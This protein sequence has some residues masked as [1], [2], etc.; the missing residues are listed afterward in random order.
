MLVEYK[1]MDDSPEPRLSDIITQ[2][3]INAAVAYFLHPVCPKFAHMERAGSEAFPSTGVLA[4]HELA[5][6]RRRRMAEIFPEVYP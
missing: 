2:H 3:N 5:A 6:L 4:T 1:P